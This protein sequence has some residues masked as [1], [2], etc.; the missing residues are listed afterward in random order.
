MYHD[1]CLYITPNIFFNYLSLNWIFLSNSPFGKYN[2]LPYSTK[3]YKPNLRSNICIT[4]PF[5][6]L[7]KYG[8]YTVFYRSNIWLF[9]KSSTSF[10]PILCG[11]PPLQR[12]IS[13]YIT[14]NSDVLTGFLGVTFKL[15]YY[16]LRG[17]QGF[18]VNRSCLVRIIFLI[19]LTLA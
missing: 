4:V 15:M 8:L 10:V 19:H 2:L 14:T 18:V 9:R 11:F 13:R 12:N 3:K 1:I 6:P 16:Y 17:C 5:I 7:R